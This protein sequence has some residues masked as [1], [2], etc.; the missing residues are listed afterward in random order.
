MENKKQFIIGSVVVIILVGAV[1]FY[2][3]TFF[4]SA[5]KTASTGSL[6]T[7]GQRTF[8]MNGS[9]RGQAGGLMRQNGGG[10][11]GEILSHDSSSITVKIGDG[12]SKI[13]FTP[14]STRITKNILGSV[15][16]LQN[17]TQV[18]IIGTP[19]ADGTLN[20]ETVQVREAIAVPVKK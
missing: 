6:A 11:I 12:G 16:D 4:G 8:Q 15:A 3:G 7:G 5:K 19:N 17:G 2:A 1:S 20:A 9:G 14:S 10:V 13:I 18:S